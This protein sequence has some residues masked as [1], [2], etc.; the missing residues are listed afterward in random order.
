MTKSLP[1]TDGLPYHK[2]VLVDEVL[3]YMDP[4]PGKLYLDVTFGSGGHTRALLEREPDCKVVALDWDLNAI[5]T[6]APLL[7]EEFGDRFRIVWGS[8]AHIYRILKKENIG[9]VDGILADFGTS[10]IQI[11]QRS[12]FSIYRDT[13]LDMRMSPQHQKVTAMQVVNYA[14]AETLREIFWQLG[15][16][17]YAKQIV[18]ALVQ[19]RKKRKITTTKQLAA[20]IE[21]VVP[22]RPKRAHAKRTIHPATKVFQAL[23]MYVNKELDNI[24]AFLAASLSALN[25]GGRIVCISFHSLE[26]R[27]VKEFFHDQAQL[28]RLH[29]LTKKVVRASEDEIMKNSSARSARLRAAQLT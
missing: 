21:R 3:Q 18:Y 23:R 4:K 24:E 27:I 10:Q 12:G 15:Q 14:T 16:E 17:N 19:E 6:Y 8:F 26:D 7:E 5:E 25:P 11:T 2:P 28:G 29:V 22:S 13:P 20:L 1:I 9:K